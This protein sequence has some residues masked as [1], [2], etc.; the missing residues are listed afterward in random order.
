M[1]CLHV[2]RAPPKCLVPMES[3][4]QWAPLEWSFNACKAPCVCSDPLD[5]LEITQTKLQ[6]QAA[7]GHDFFLSQ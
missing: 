7:F 2:I 1:F 6:Y 3:R 5:E 4:R